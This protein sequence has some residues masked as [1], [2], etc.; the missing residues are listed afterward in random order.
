MRRVLAGAGAGAGGG[1]F[2]GSVR[3]LLRARRSSHANLMF[4]EQETRPG[5]AS[6]SPHSPARLGGPQHYQQ[7]SDPGAN[8][9]H[10]LLIVNNFTCSIRKLPQIYT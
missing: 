2:H 1:T 4:G 6:Q 5:Q 8:N 7:Y 9:S 3:G 10:R